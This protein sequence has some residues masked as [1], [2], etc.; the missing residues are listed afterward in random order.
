VLGGG[1][2]PLACLVLGGGGDPPACLVLGGGGDPLGMAETITT[3]KATNKET[4]IT[5]ILSS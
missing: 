5:I 3:V 2:D 1:G 4:L